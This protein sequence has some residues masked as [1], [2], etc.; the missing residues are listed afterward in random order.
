[1]DQTIII[2]VAQTVKDYERQNPDEFRAFK[3]QQKA[4]QDT[5]ENEFAGVRGDHV[6]ERQLFTLPELLFNMIRMSLTEDEHKQIWGPDPKCT[7]ALWFAKTYPQYR[8][9]KKY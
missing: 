2:K 6:T 5:M 4:L 1:M 9:G 3:A 7:G 8:A